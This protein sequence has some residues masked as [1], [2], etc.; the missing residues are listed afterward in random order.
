MLIDVMR[1]FLCVSKNVQCGTKG[2]FHIHTGRK[3]NR[4]YENVKEKK[5]I[6]EKN[7]LSL[8]LNGP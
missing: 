1:L 3:W 4:K 8:S 6:K 5:D 7:S 2:S